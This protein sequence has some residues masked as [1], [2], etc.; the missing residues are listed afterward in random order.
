M[1]PQC[2]ITLNLLRYSRRQPNLSAYAATFG[3]FNF[4]QTPL[5]PPGTRVLV[6]ETTKQRASFAPHGVDGWYIGPSVDHY[7]CYNCYIP[8]TS[9]TCNSISVDW[10]P[11]PIPF[12]NVTTDDYLTQTAE[13]M[14]D[15][16]RQK[17]ASTRK[18]PS[19]RSRMAQRYKTPTQ[20]W[21]ELLQ[22]APEMPIAPQVP[23]PPPRVETLTQIEQPRDNPSPQITARPPRVETN[24]Q[25]KIRKIKEYHKTRLYW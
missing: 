14:L 24:N 20:K 16:I 19:P 23:A 21:P 6:H 12:P 22:R 2:D 13:D 7:R 18:T 25:H 4:N 15:L 8:S 5:A 1:L 17:L 3:N 11:H 10:F 9:G